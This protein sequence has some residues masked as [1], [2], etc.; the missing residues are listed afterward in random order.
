MYLFI[1]I[2]ELVEENPV[3]KLEDH[4]STK[5]LSCQ[6]SE[7]VEENLNSMTTSNSSY[8]LFGKLS[9]AM[10]SKSAEVK[11]KLIEYIVNPTGS[12]G[13]ATE[14]HVKSSDKVSKRYRNMA[15]VFSIDDDDAG[16]FRSS[17]LC[18]IYNMTSFSH[19]LR[20]SCCN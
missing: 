9:A 6:P 17:A 4:I 14:R 2:H 16:K 5:C 15:P 20:S 8:E 1:A 3:I 19:L 13:Q 7:R 10:K 12:N 18:S 11:E